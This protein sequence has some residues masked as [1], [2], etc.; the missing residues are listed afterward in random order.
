M[1]KRRGVIRDTLNEY[2]KCYQWLTE[3]QVRYAFSKYTKGLEVS[4]IDTSILVIDSNPPERM[5]YDE[6]ANIV[7][8]DKV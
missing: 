8:I 6:T 7:N 2:H 4:L 1:S 5:T 3:R